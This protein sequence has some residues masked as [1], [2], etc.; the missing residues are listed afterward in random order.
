[1][2][3]V[4]NGVRWTEKRLTDEQLSLLEDAE[5]RNLGCLKCEG[6]TEI[7]LEGSIL[8]IKGDKLVVENTYMF[9][10]EIQSV[11]ASYCLF[12]GKKL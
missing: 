4:L 2:S 3:S 6:V 9:E 10:N 7:K 1:M 12:C 5:K 8:S 11:Q